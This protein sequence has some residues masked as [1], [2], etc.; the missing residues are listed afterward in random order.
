MTPLE[1]GP[2]KRI[3]TTR[4][5]DIPALVERLSQGEGDSSYADESTGT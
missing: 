3:D 4:P 5:V 1:L 2:T